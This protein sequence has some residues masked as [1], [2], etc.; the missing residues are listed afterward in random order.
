MPYAKIETNVKLGKLKEQKLLKAASVFF[1]ALLKKSEEHVMVSVSHETA[2]VFGKNSDPAAYVELKS[3][4]ITEEIC[5]DL[6]KEICSFLNQHLDILPN[7]T[8]IE[9][10][11][12]NGKMFGCNNKTF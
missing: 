4:A 1:A 3:M 12:I 6:S 7:R 5:T 2:F 8:Y 9:F 10:S 11:T